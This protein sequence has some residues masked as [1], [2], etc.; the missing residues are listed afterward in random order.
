[1]GEGDCKV[2]VSEMIIQLI[3]WGRFLEFRKPEIK[4]ILWEFSFISTSIGSILAIFRKKLYSF[5]DN[6][7]MTEGWKNFL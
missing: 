6:D 7:R 1:M 3:V 5:G 4:E 2:E